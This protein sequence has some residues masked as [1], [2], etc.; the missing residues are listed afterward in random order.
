MCP[1]ASRSGWGVVSY[2]SVAF[3]WNHM[4]VCFI[5]TNRYRDIFTFNKFRFSHA[6]HVTRA[7]CLCRCEAAGTTCCPS[8]RAAGRA[9]PT[10]VSPEH[11]A[12]RHTQGSWYLT[13]LHVTTPRNILLF[14]CPWGLNCRALP[15]VKTSRTT[16][17]VFQI[18]Y[19][20]TLI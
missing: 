12:R 3:I 20:V 13:V 6:D 16:G 1:R 4:L 5:N 19:Q 9:V 8:S 7:Y 10:V 2:K 14:W 15:L 11:A 18:H 17:I